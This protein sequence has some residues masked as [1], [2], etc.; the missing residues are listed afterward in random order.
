MEQQ[1]ER[2]ADEHVR[3]KR[4]AEVVVRERQPEREDEHEH[5]TDD[6][7]EM[8]GVRRRAVRRINLAQRLGARPV[9]WWGAAGRTLAPGW[10]LATAAAMTTRL[11]SPTLRT[12]IAG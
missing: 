4:P 9:A 7:L 8:H 5:D 11:A 6:R 10:R 3:R 12:G 2:V 1:P